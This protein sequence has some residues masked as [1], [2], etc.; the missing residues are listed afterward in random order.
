MGLVLV[1]CTHSGA[2]KP[3]ARTLVFQGNKGAASS[4][5][6]G[7]HRVDA[8]RQDRHVRRH[9]KKAKKGSAAMKCDDECQADIVGTY[10]QREGKNI[11]EK[12]YQASTQ[13]SSATLVAAVQFRDLDSAA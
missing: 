6:S 8:P 11:C 2:R 7:F 4:S 13:L 12:C 5:S 9:S 3:H 10:F 1:V